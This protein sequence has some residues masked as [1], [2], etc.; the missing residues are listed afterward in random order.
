MDPAGK[1]LKIPLWMTFSEAAEVGV[2]RQAHLS[3][4]SLFEACLA[5]SQT[6]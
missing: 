5:R 1:R 4:G 2:T 3:G 6:A